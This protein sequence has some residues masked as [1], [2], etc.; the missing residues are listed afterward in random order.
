M[1]S[2]FRSTQARTT[3]AL[4]LLAGLALAPTRAA[5]QESGAE[6]KPEGHRRMLAELEELRR[7]SLETNI[8]SG[9]AEARQ[10]RRMLAEF[11]PT[12]KPGK[13]WKILQR[14]GF[15]ELRLGNE[16]AAIEALTEALEEVLPTLKA[17]VKKEV[18]VKV[19]FDLGVAWMR[20]GETQNCVARHTSNSC[21]LPIQGDGVH[22]DQEGSRKAMEIFLTVLEKDPDHVGAK[23]LLNLAAMTV[24]E[25]PDG[26]PERYR[27]PPEAFESDVEFPRFWDVAP[28]R[29]INDNNLSGGA[30]ADDFD[31]DGAIDI[32]TSTMDPRGPMLYYRGHGDGTFTDRTAEA[33]LEGFTGGLNMCQAD[34][35]GDGDIDVLVL[36]GAWLR[37]NGRYPNSLLR[38]DGQGRFTDVTYE[39]GIGVA[40]YPTQT[41][42]WADYDN[43]GD[44]DVMIGNETDPSIQAPCQLFRNNGDGTFTDVAREA[45]VLN[46]HFAKA[47]AWGDYDEDRWPDLFVSNQNGSNRLYHNQ[48]DGTFEDVAVYAG[49]LRPQA[50][51]PSWWWDFDNDG[52]L[53][54]FVS[55]YWPALEPFA[56]S[57]LGLPPRAEKAALYRGDGKGGFENVARA[58][59]LDAI[60]LPM[61]SNF[62]DLDGDGFLDFYLGTGYPGY[63]GLMPNAMYWNRA[64]KSF[65][66][67]T[68]PGGFGHLQKGHG[69]AFADFDR[70]G[71]QDVFI[72]MGGA[73]PG[74]AFG[75]AL[76][77]NPGFGTRWVSV[78]LVGEQSNSFGIGARI[79]CD[80]VE[81]EATRS[82]YRHVNSGG[83]FGCSPLTQT[84]GLGAAERLARLEVY[85]PTSDTTQ[86]F[87]DVPM[88]RTLVIT[89]GREDYVS[90]SR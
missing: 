87:E 46:N 63:E 45:G 79:R 21:I 50:S 41:A 1:S 78:R 27:I 74:D 75:N 30:I 66:D 51:F 25:Y 17:K 90:S 4:A 36:R 49:V 40:H 7:T 24:A 20:Y 12:D 73:F 70:D 77:E 19:H 83:S 76:F 80:V 42:A 47:V 13:R 62:G 29:G 18:L 60:T 88:E 71:D 55:S 86:V 53:D 8:Y 57:F 48:G 72:Q 64:G 10:F 65:V 11:K 16:K 69:V 52:H 3:L 15:H 89:E 9:V 35:D 84:I 56:A 58:M 44:L 82:I 22:V 32:V 28:E 61:G 31:G 54:L 68:L 39:S 23:W 81:G 85:W 14:L 6:Q 34:Y 2:R 33:G 37:A 5:G 43:D 38:N 67:V 26:V 59:G